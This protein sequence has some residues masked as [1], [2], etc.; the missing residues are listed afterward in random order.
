M[1]PSVIL[2][3]ARPGGGAYAEEH[4]RLAFWGQLREDKRAPITNLR[5]PKLRRGSGVFLSRVHLVSVF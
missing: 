5:W 2:A 1:W 3:D 4:A